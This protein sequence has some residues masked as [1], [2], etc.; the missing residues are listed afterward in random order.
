MDLLYLNQGSNVEPMEIFEQYTYLGHGTEGE[1]NAR[2]IEK[3]CLKQKYFAFIDND[4]EFPE[5]GWVFHTI[6]PPAP[7]NIISSATKSCKKEAAI[8][9]NKKNHKKFK[10]LKNKLKKH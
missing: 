1:S 8:F 3:I 7:T 10:F 9:S 5:L 4:L 2:L 6:L